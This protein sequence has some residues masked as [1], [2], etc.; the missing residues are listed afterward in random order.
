VEKLPKNR[1]D[2]YFSAYFS[3]DRLSQKQN[4]HYI[5]TVYQNGT[6]VPFATT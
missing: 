4:S 2:Q 6:G 5:E 3:S 1:T